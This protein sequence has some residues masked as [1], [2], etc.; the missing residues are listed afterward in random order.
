MKIRYAID[1]KIVWRILY[2]GQDGNE[3]V[4]KKGKELITN[5]LR[6]FRCYHG[7]Y[8]YSAYYLSGT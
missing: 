5:E 8:F 7:S 2:N 6:D 3:I 4:L 1:I